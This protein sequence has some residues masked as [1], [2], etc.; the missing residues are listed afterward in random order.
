MKASW[1]VDSQDSGHLDGTYKFMIQ[2]T[3]E[4]IMEP[5]LNEPLLIA[6]HDDSES[7]T[8]CSLLRHVSLSFSPSLGRW[9]ACTSIATLSTCIGFIIAARISTS[10]ESRQGGLRLSSRSDI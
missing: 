4:H 10:N 2:S 5:W 3:A 9:T 8:K 6:E 1:E 7:S